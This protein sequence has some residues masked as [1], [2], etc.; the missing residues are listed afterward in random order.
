MVKSLHTSEYEAFRKLLT[1]TRRKRGLTQSDVA[2]A[3]GRHQSFVTKYERGERRL[4]VIE[5]VQVCVA[6]GVDP[7]GMLKEIQKKGLA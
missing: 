6:L 3:L 2:T 5:F 4:D 7:V 1:D